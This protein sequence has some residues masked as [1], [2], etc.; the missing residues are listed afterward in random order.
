[1]RDP[2]G[3]VNNIIP[4]L[5]HRY[6]DSTVSRPHHIYSG[7]QCYASGTTDCGDTPTIH[8]IYRSHSAVRLLN[9]QTSHI[10]THLHAEGIIGNRSIHTRQPK[11]HLIGMSRLTD[12]INGGNTK[13]SLL[14]VTVER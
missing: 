1:M 8:G 4:A 5:R 6:L 11:F 13:G 3:S 7:R 12:G 10:G 9:C 14:L 2:E